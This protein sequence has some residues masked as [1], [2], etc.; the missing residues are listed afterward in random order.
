MLVGCLIRFDREQYSWKADSSQIFDRKTV[1]IA[2]PMFHVGIIFIFFGH[3]FG[4]LT[5]HSW[6]LAMGVS[7]NAHQ[8]LAISAGTLFGVICWIGGTMLLLRRLR[9]PKVRAASRKRDIFVLAWLMLTLTLGLCTI[10][11]S[12][13]HALH[14]NADTMIHLSGWAQSLVLLS[15]NWEAVMQVGLIYK[16]HLFCGLTIFMIFPF[17]RLVHVF[18]F[19]FGYIVRPYQVVRSKNFSSR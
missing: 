8:I 4:L 15:P 14:G 7:D 10:P 11:F 12:V 1:V 17:T 9:H 2:S 5:P 3:F 6:F 13:Y 18:S 19:P 16:M